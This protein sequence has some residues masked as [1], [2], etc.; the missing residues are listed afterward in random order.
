MYTRVITRHCG[1]R[2]LRRFCIY[3]LYNTC[4]CRLQS[5]Q[6]GTYDTNVNGQNFSSK[7]TM[8]ITLHYYFAHC[9]AEMYFL[10][11]RRLRFNF[12]PDSNF[13]EMHEKSMFSVLSGSNSHYSTPP[14]VS[15]LLP[16]PAAL[17]PLFI[18]TPPFKSHRTVAGLNFGPC[19]ID[20]T[21]TIAAYIREYMFNISLP[22]ETF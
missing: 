2:S 9:G 11:S 5:T 13:H 10:V 12:P 22:V 16:L 1:N 6:L 18:C 4:I 21:H 3:L 14:R 8:C 20:I 15:A 7:I 19:T 17:L